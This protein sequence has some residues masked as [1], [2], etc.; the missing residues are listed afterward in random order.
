MEVLMVTEVRRT[1]ERL[2][3]AYI[4]QISPASGFRIPDALKIRKI[5][6]ILRRRAYRWAGGGFAWAKRPS[7]FVSL[8]QR[9]VVG[10]GF[11]YANGNGRPTAA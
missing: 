6:F 2:I 9:H 7:D 8:R 3:V 11:L 4:L 5:T 10:D 1:P